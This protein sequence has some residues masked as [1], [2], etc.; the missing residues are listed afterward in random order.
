MKSQRMKTWL[1]MAAVGGSVLL[2]PLIASA[3]DDAAVVAQRQLLDKYCIVCHNNEDYAGRIDFEAY[4][5][6]NP[7]DDAKV[8]EK[9]LKKLRVGMMPP[10]GKARPDPAAVHDLVHSLETKIDAHE[11]ASLSVPKLHRLNRVEYANAVRDL[12][13]LDIDSSKFLPTDDSSRGFDN[14]AGALTLSSA[15][16]DA[17][18][19]AAA[20]VSSVAIGEAA[21]PGQV[22][23]RI[24]QDTTQNYHVEGLPFG[25]RGGIVI[26]HTFPSD[27][28]YTFKVI[29]VTLGNMGSDR[30]F[31]EVKGE[32]LLVYVDD[33]RVAKIDW[34]KAL[35]VGRRI[36]ATAD[37]EGAAAGQLK[38]IDVK[39]P[40][41]AGPH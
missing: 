21:S 34:D 37:D 20:R 26:D 22:T 39:L 27:G 1:P 16:L 31:G 24:P 28:N 13:A 36:A 18:L 38:P 5:P 3:R 23:Y 6:A 14:Q 11:K 33:K 2:M 7:Q 29:A 12:L 17:Y 8:T 35:G 19:S 25:T 4:D 9:I 15:L 40:L 41:T 32:Q 30:P 10:A